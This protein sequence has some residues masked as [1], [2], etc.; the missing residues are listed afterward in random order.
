MSQSHIV[1]PTA[2]LHIRGTIHIRGTMHIRAGRE[3]TEGVS[4]GELASFIRA[5]EV[6]PPCMDLSSVS[7]RSS[8]F[9]CPRRRSTILSSTL[10][11]AVLS[12]PC[13]GTRFPGY[14]ISLWRQQCMSHLAYATASPIC[15]RVFTGSTTAVNFVL[16]SLLITGATSRSTTLQLCSENTVD[17]AQPFG[18]K[19]SQHR[20]CAT[21]RF[22][23]LSSP[24]ERL[25]KKFNLSL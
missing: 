7:A 11:G 23:T 10:I 13:K 9:V 6:F 20:L 21:T 18:W 25:H 2:A 14:H 16:V 12:S 22:D 17:T 4:L 3:L 15:V 24:G 19:K 1:A 5:L 8:D